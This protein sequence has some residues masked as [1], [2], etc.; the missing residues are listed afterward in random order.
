MNF[1]QNFLEMQSDTIQ[2]AVTLLD[3][4]MSRRK[5]TIQKIQLLGITCLLVAVKFNEGF[6]PTVCRLSSEA[7]FLHFVELILRVCVDL[8]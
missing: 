3:Q 8:M 6:P 2:L 5:V 4:F 1:V 7:Y